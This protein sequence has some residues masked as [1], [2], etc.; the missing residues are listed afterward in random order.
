MVADCGH[1]P[2]IIDIQPM[3]KVIRGRQV[4]LDNDLATLCGVETRVWMPIFLDK[5][6]KEVSAT[7]YM[8]KKWFGFTLMRDLQPPNPIKKT[9]D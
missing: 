4:M 7:I 1:L 8:G 6:G 3:I 5:R 2:E 9:K